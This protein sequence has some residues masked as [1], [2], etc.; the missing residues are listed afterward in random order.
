MAVSQ[1]NRETGTHRVLQPR[2]DWVVVA[3]K[4]RHYSAAVVASLEMYSYLESGPVAAA[5]NPA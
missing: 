4:L 2:P 5:S 3:T 1:I